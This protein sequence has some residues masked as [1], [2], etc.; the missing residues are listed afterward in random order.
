VLHHMVI[1]RTLNYH[2]M[3]LHVYWNL[4]NARR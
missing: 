2:R 4:N 3:P 1:G